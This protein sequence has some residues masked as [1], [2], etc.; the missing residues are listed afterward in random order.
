MFFFLLRKNR[1]ILRINMHPTTKITIYALLTIALV[2]IL[3]DYIVILLLVI[4][5]IHIFKTLVE[6]SFQSDKVNL[7]HYRQWKQQYL[8]SPEWKALK[9][10]VLNRD[11]FTCQSCNTDGIPLEVHHIT[12][13]NFGNENLSDLVSLCRN[14]HQS[15]H[16]KHGYDYNKLYP[17]R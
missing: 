4:Y 14:C 1:N 13:Q 9:S 12:Y 10:K 16:D 11:N 15:I 3:Q 2:L 5:I 8:K 17:L 6:K 7:N